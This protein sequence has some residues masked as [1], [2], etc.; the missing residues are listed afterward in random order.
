MVHNALRELREI[1]RYRE[2]L[3]N[4]V[5]RDIKVRYRRS[6][7]GFIWVMLNPFLMML[8]LY[9]IFSELFKVTAENYAVYLL[10]GIVLWNFFAQ[11]T[12]ITVRSFLMNS[13]LIKKIY[14]PKSI[15]PLS[16]I[17]SALVNL[18]FSLIPLYIILMFTGAPK[19]SGIYLVPV[20][21]FLL[22]CF[23]LG[24]S[25]LLSV[26]TVFFHDMVYIYEAVLL[27]WM[28]ATPIFY[29]ES[30]VPASFRILLHVNPLYYI[31]S[32]FRGGL[33]M[34]LPATDNFLALGVAF[35]IFF[36][37]AGYALY[38]VYRDRI[39]YQL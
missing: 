30:I 10:S 38:A 4:L 16:T 26:I 5:L 17:L 19:L 37:V 32:L 11:A 15:F 24:L 31:L 25:L 3:R 6:I 2:L 9:V 33:Y 18:A 8:I 7:L 13:N 12:S 22:F 34:D 35:S 21:L 27:A 23:S 14:L 36:L 39:V 28:Y 29:P 1:V 20:S